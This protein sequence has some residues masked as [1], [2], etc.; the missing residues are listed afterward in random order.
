VLCHVFAMSGVVLLRRD[1]P[2]W[3]RPIKVS[4]LWIGGAVLLAAFDTLLLVWG[5]WNS[6]LAWGDTSKSTVFKAILVL[7][8]AAVLYVWRVV[9]QEKKPLKLRLPSPR[10]PEE[11]AQMADIPTASV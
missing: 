8:I 1:R 2:D 7:L 9:A 6:G 5:G 10:T 4:Q 3:P 11:E